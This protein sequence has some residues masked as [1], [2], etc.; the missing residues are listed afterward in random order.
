MI[1]FLREACNKHHAYFE[2]TSSLNKMTTSCWNWITWKHSSCLKTTLIYPSISLSSISD[3]GPED[4]YGKDS[5][6]EMSLSL[7]HP[8]GIQ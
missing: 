1:V 3:C 4:D 6:E 8:P 5:K 7:I 2:P